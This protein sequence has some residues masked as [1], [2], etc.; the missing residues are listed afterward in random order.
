VDQTCID[1]EDHGSQR[2]EPQEN[3]NASAVLHRTGDI[4]MNAWDSVCIDTEKDLS[5]QI[6]K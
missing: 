6:Q 3:Q 5:I 4:D 2:R 1:I